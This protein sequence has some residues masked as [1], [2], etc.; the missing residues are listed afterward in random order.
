[1]FFIGASAHF[2]PYLLLSMTMLVCFVHQG[3]A[4]K[5]VKGMPVQ[6]Y[7][8]AQREIKIVATKKVNVRQTN[9]EQQEQSVI[10]NRI[11]EKTSDSA[12]IR[13]Y[14]KLKRFTVYSE[15]PHRAPPITLKNRK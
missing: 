4:D 15:K 7:A 6:V 13:D 14:S 3:K 1:M 11:A 12:I 10:N 2:I 8:Q 9:E 5:E